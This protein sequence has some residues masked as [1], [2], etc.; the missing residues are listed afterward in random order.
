MLKYVTFENVQAYWI[1][2]ASPKKLSI[3]IYPPLKSYL[4]KS[5]LCKLFKK[6][7]MVCLLID[8]NT[9]DIATHSI[10]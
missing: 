3:P 5:T 2:N 7:S 10:Y 6:L 4:Q 8:E 1:G 9:E